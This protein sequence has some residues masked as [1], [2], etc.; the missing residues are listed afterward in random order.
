VGTCADRNGLVG[1]PSVPWNHLGVIVKI[2]KD[3]IIVQNYGSP[4]SDLILHCFVF[5]LKM[6]AFIIIARHMPVKKFAKE[7]LDLLA[8]TSMFKAI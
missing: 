7:H 4:T 6:L 1:L 5:P 3:I 8:D 2:I